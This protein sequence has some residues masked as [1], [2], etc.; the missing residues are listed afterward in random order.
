MAHPNRKATDHELLQQNALGRSL[1]GVGDIFSLHPTSVSARL[2]NLGV[3]PA[4]TR[5]S[6]MDEVLAGLTP[7]QLS[8]LSQQVSPEKNI[9][10]LVRELIRDRYI[11]QN[12]D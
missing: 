5:R 1:Q 6:F 12:K 9:K 7:D 11:T 8:W 3:A 2:R 10:S 4:D